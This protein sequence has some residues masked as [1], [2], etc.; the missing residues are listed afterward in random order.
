MAIDDGRQSPSE[1][2]ED[3]VIVCHMHDENNATLGSGEGLSVGMALE[4]TIRNI[5]DEKGSIS[6]SG[7]FGCSMEKEGEHTAHE[8]ASSIQKDPDNIEDLPGTDID[9]R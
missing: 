3:D 2:L 8:R 7:S 5:E 9:I 6:M 1:E 4:R